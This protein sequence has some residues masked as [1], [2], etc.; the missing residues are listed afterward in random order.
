MIGPADA[1]HAASGGLE[2]AG[3]PAARRAEMAVLGA[4]IIDPEAIGLVAG[5]VRPDDFVSRRL[6]LVYEA[7]L[8]LHGRG[9]QPD[10]ATLCDELDARGTMAAVG[11]IGMVTG[12]INRCPTS[13]HAAHYARLIAE[14]GERRRAG[15][16][17]GYALPRPGTWG[18]VE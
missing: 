15:A 9:I 12:L 8:A 13:L 1:E 11:G 18:V 10:Y 17:G 6:R 3:H 7:A 5:L 16:A 4:L 2:E 14:A